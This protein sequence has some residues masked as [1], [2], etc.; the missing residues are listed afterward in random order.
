MAEGGVECHKRLPIVPLSDA[1]QVIRVVEKI[2][3]LASGSK[4][5][6]ISGWGYLFRAVM[7]FKPRLSM[8]DQKLLSFLATKK[9]PIGDDD[10]Q[11]IP[12]FKD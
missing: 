3:A 10:R 11:I 12:A 1:H 4:A 7:L 6:L 9:G 5:E 8:Q 2:V